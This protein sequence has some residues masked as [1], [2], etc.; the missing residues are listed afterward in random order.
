MSSFGEMGFLEWTQYYKSHN[1][2][3]ADAIIAASASSIDALLVTLNRKHFPMF[4]GDQILT[5]HSKI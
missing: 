3:L 4:N 2:G 5:P 1:V